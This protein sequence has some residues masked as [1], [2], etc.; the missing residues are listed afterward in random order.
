MRL[1]E[2]LKRHNIPVALDASIGTFT[3]ASTETNKKSGDSIILLNPKLV[4]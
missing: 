2:I 1:A 3:L 4:N